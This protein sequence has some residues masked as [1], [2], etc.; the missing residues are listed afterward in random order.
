VSAA[1][2]R[3]VV[4]ELARILEV[5][6]AQLPPEAGLGAFEKWDSLNHIAI[7]MALEAAFGVEVNEETI[8][9][10]TSTDAIVD[11]LERRG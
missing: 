11:Y 4:A 7:L 9:T 6:A 8:Q 3:Q 10:L 2:R 1:L 5:P